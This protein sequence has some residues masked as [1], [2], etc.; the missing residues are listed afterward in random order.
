MIRGLPSLARL[1]LGPSGLGL[2]LELRP[3]TAALCRH[4]RSLLPARTSV[5][6]RK[7]LHEDAMQ[8]LFNDFYFNQLQAILTI[9]GCICWTH[10]PR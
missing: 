7:N 3:R 10:S 5:Y 1:A 4:L 2:G 8:D 9:K 6:R